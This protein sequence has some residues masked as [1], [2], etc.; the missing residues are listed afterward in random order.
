[1]KRIAYPLLLLNVVFFIQCSNSRI[2]PEPPGPGT[3][4]E[5]KSKV[6]LNILIPKSNVST[7]A[8]VDATKLENHIEILYVD[9]YQGGSLIKQEDFS[10]TELTVLMNSNDSIVTVGY[11]VDN[12]TTG[13][14][15]AKVFANSRTVRVLAGTDSV[16]LPKGDAATSFF[17]SGEIAQI[18]YDAGSGTY[19]ADIPLQRNVAKIRVNV[20]K[21]TAVLPSDLEI[22]Y[23]NIKIKTLNIANQT[24][25]FG[26]ANDATNTYIETDERTGALLHKSS[27]FS[28]NGG[29]IDSFYVYENCRA[30]FTELSHATRVQIEIP[31]ISPTEGSK[32]DTYTY[33]LYISPDGYNLK[34]NFI[35]TLDIKV[36]GQSLEPVITTSIQP[37]NDVNIDGTIHGTYL[38][39]DKSEIVFD[40]YGKAVINFCTDAQA[41]YFNFEEFNNA[42]TVIGA[43]IGSKILYPISDDPGLLRIEDTD[44]NLAPSDFKDGQILLDKQHCG[45]FGFEINLNEYPSFP[46]VNF[47]GKICVRAGNI[48]KCLSFPGIRTY[49]AHFIVGDSIFN[50]NERYISAT[51]LPVSESW[52]RVSVNRL[53]NS[54]DMKQTYNGPSTPLYLHLDENLTG[55]SRKGT[56]TVITENGA[57]KT[58]NLEQLP[59]IPIGRFGYNSILTDDS[60]Y[61]AML[62]TEQLYEFKTE[63]TYIGTGTNMPL[64]NAIYNGRMSAISVFDGAKYEETNNYFNYQDALYQAINYC[65]HKN[66]ITSGGNINDQLLW[67]LPSQAQLAG[68]WISYNSYKDETTSNFNYS[69]GAPA[70]YFWSSTNNNDYPDAQ[71]MNFEFGNIGHRLRETKYWVRCVRDGTAATPPTSTMILSSNNYPVIDFGNGMPTGSYT[72]ISKTLNNN[73]GGDELSDNNKTLFKTL[74]VAI[75]DHASGVPWDINACD[76]YTAEGET[77]WRLPTQRELQAI[78]ILQSEI[79]DEFPSFD[80]LADDYYYWSATDSKTN[81]TNAWIIC[82]SRTKPGSSGNAP[83]HLKSETEKLNVRCVREE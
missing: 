62:Y 38:T 25:L 46:A 67:Y 61:G 43:E 80:L 28:A 81:G 66:R 16:P 8:G 54:G 6:S 65:A 55:S 70:D 20:S 60:I 52:L 57:E 18:N 34:R 39:M 36:R 78:W 47:S 83:N 42:N 19:K 11:E 71:Y 30:S 7:Y 10:G 2:D 51:V 82:G 50:W 5:G 12:I 1:M 29:Q 74:R 24:A 73:A 35:Y 77:D 63:P 41:V 23:D 72:T 45:S 79:K 64:V 21:H 37:W 31:T 40:S 13:T 32:K 17:M 53:Y 4:P 48:V 9:L 68:M 69:N 27:S 58:L 33:S 56:V 3:D 15:S 49:D 76:G 22:D 26:P 14:L 75:A 44:P 59:A